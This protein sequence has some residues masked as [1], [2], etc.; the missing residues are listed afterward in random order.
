MNINSIKSKVDKLERFYIG[1]DSHICSYTDLQADEGNVLEFISQ[2]IGK[3][4]IER[5]EPLKKPITSKQAMLNIMACLTT[6]E[7]NKIIELE[8]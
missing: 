8:S 1:G 4:F 7:I 3:S 5:L 6:E 2:Y